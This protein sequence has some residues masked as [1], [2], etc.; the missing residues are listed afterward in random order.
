MLKPSTGSLGFVSNWNF[1]SR[2]KPSCITAD[3]PQHAS[4]ETHRGQF[5]CY[6]WPPAPLVVLGAFTLYPLWDPPPVMWNLIPLFIKGLPH[7]SLPRICMVR[8][9][10]LPCPKRPSHWP[11][12]FNS[13]CSP[14]PFSSKSLSD[15]PVGIDQTRPCFTVTISDSD[16]ESQQSISEETI[17]EEPPFLLLSQSFKGSC[18]T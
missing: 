9:C 18:C 15:S 10:I 1:A 7:Q 8:L 4:I 3:R 17:F 5:C 2:F 14:A 6:W 13:S 11:H 16:S 12:T